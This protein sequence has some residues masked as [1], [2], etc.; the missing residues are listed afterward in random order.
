M[1][2]WIDKGVD[3]V[4]HGSK[5]EHLAV[6]GHAPAL[7]FVGWMWRKRRRSAAYERAGNAGLWPQPIPRGL[8]T[9]QQPWDELRECRGRVLACDRSDQFD[10][11]G[12]YLSAGSLEQWR[13]S[14]TDDGGLSRHRHKLETRFCASFPLLG[15]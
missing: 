11:S 4:T 2:I 12:R 6:N 5:Q 14:R 3:Y 7:S 10:P 13:S 15:G 8:P 9:G 1:H